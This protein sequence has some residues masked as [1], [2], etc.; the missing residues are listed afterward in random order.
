MKFRKPIYDTKEQVYRVD[1]EDGIRFQNLRE[2]G[3]WKESLDIQF[4]DHVEILS[5]EVIRQTQGW[6]SKPLT[7]EYLKPRLQY[8]CP[9]E[10]FGDFEGTVEWEFKTLL[11]SKQSF[12]FHLALVSKTPLEKLVIDFLED[13]DKKSESPQL[14]EDDDSEPLTVGPTR[15]RLFK[16]H[17]MQIRAK[18]ARALYKA[19]QLTQAYCE[20]FGDETDWE[21]DE[22]EED[23]DFEEEEEEA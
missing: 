10:D 22:E 11:I 2:G 1:I 4:Y 5:D 9:T 17:V 19:E 14:E 23:S 12:V 8:Q 20:E 7:P 21:D 13:D 6:F 16:E 15:R 18:A 3:E